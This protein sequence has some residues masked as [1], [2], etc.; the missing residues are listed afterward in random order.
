LTVLA[1][2][3][4]LSM[5]ENAEAGDPDGA[6]V[7]DPTAE[8]FMVTGETTVLTYTTTLL[9]DGT[10]LVTGYP[11]NT[12]PGGSPP[13]LFDSATSS[14]FTTGDM[15][16][17]R[18]HH[19]ATLLPDGTVLVSGGECLS[20]VLAT[21]EIYHPAVSLPSPVLFAWSSDGQGAILHASTHQ[22]VS[23]NN[24]AVAGEAV[25]LYLTGLIDGAVI[26]PQVVVG[27]LTAEVLFFGRAPGYDLLNQVNI[28]VPSEIATGPAV[29]VRINYIGRPSNAV[30]IA[31]Q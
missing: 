7:Y 13:V 14:F 12:P 5:L 17:P 25:E 16:T 24:P 22:L 23:P 4:V 8:A 28:R 18:Y 9:P 26:P 15:V 3:K 27:G 19:T 29:P 1:N 11:L 30:T 31:I 2:G 10:V 21:A 20:G 6:A